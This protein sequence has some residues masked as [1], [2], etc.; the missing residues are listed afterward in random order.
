MGA[1]AI[2]K[3]FKDC[4]IKKLIEVLQSVPDQDKKV[5]LDMWNIPFDKE[6]IPFGLVECDDCV[7]IKIKPKG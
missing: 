6:L 1:N 2:S 5:E 3:D 4:T 7:L